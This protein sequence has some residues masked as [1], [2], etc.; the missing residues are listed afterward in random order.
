MDFMRGIGYGMAK[1]GPYE[2]IEKTFRHRK[3]RKPKSRPNFTMVC[4]TILKRI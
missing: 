1:L 4:T 3:G 2:S